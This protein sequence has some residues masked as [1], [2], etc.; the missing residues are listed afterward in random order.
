MQ[1]DNRTTIYLSICVAIVLWGFSFI[2]TNQLLIFEIPI[3]TFITARMV[4]AGVIMLAVSSISGKLQKIAIKEFP[5][6]LLMALFEPFIYFIGE[7]FGMKYT[8]SPTISSVIIA[9]IPIFTLVSGQIFFKEKVSGLNI[10]AIL[11]TI[12]GILLMVVR[13][14]EFGIDY[15]YGI[16]ILFIAVFGAV[17]YTTIV[18][19]L[20]EKYNSYTIATW[21]FLLAAIYFLPTYFIF[22]IDKIPLQRL[23]HSDTLIPIICLAVLCSCLAFVLFINSIR[24]L[25]ITRASV[26]TAMIPAVSALGAYIAGH[27][28]FTT[29]QIIGIVVV[30][31]GVIFA[32]Y[33]KPLRLN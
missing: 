32:Q 1:S 29:M 5:I 11:M 15:W 23:L 28:S 3:F 2:W 16:L 18:R 26:F 24:H 33:Q 9:T 4:L 10:A 19:K 27:E 20:T 12:P 6:F 31:N 25:G 7:S 22:D 17:G 8:N 21:Q 13:Q 14:G 30:I